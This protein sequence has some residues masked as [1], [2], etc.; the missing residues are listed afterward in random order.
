MEG[1]AEAARDVIGFM[2]AHVDQFRAAGITTLIIDHQGKL[3]TGERY[4]SKTQFGSSYKKHLSRSVFQIE[5]R[6]STEEDRKI[7]FRQTKTNFGPT[8][9][10]FGVKVTW[11]FEKITVEPDQ[12]SQADLAE[13]ESVRVIKR[14]ITA[15]EQGPKY[16]DELA[17]AL[18]VEVKTVKNRLSTLLREGKIEGTGE[19]HKQARQVSLVS[20]TIRDGDG[21][22]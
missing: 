13:E 18:G 22:T 2:R 3:Q 7:T 10:P 4:Q 5:T 12:L 16:P 17:E 14:I 9:D 19:K 21:D 11:E 20:P 8:L 1:D 6:E 15:L